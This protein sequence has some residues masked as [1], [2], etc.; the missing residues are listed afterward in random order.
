M[1][2]WKEGRQGGAPTSGSSSVNKLPC[3]QLVN[4]I[5]FTGFV[6]LML[7]FKSSLKTNTEMVF[8]S[9]TREALVYLVEEAR[10]LDSFVQTK[11]QCGKLTGNQANKQMS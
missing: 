9:K 11:T 1:S 7:L 4:A 3:G 6:L 10:P 8:A 5:I 2:N